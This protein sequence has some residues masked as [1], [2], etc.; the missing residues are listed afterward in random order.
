MMHQN[1]FVIILDWIF[2][3]LYP[4]IFSGI[5]I[6]VGYIIYKVIKSQ[7]GKLSEKDK[8]KENTANNIIRVLKCLIILFVISG[9]AMQFSEGIALITTMFTIIGGTILGFAAMNTLGNMIAGIIIMVSKPFTVGDR[10]IFN[11][12]LA[13]V[14]EIKL[15][16]TELKDLDDIKIS[17]PNQNLIS[18]E[19]QNLGEKN[20]IR[21][22]VTVTPGFDVD[23]KKVEK[24]LLEAAMKVPEVLENPEPYV[25]INKF[26]N[27]AVEY[28][29]F[30]FINDI[31]NLPRI[32][33][34]LHKI[35]FDE[36]YENGIDISTPLL[37][38]KL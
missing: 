8:L 14:I 18:N 35:V 38:K 25:W 17:I 27:Y 28:S 10:I 15:V 33:S 23:R 2:I 12:K 21:R 1:I 6:I 20:V 36:C 24:V 19:I 11:D 16:Y 34:D 37:M 31:K 4:L 7:I 26:Q 30:V 32:D 5:A 22:H 13:D 29:L 9:I 3:N